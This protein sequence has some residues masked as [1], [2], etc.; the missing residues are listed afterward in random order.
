MILSQRYKIKKIQIFVE[1]MGNTPIFRLYIHRHDAILSFVALN[2]MATTSHIRRLNRRRVLEMLLHQQTASRTQLAKSCEM[3]QPTVSRIVEDLLRE[4]ILVEVDGAQDKPAIGR[5]S[6]PL[7]FDSST[8]RFL[9][10][11]IGVAQTRIAAIPLRMP[12]ADGWK[13][14]FATPQRADPWARQLEESLEQVQ[15]DNHL[16]TVICLPGVIDERN[17]RV[18]LSP[19][20]RWTEQTDISTLLGKLQDRPVLFIQEIKALALGHSLF[21]PTAQ[22]FLL[23]DSGSGVGAAIIMQGRLYTGPLPLSGE[24]GHTSI[25][26]NQRPC[27]CGSKGCIETLISRPGIVATSVENSGPDSWEALLEYLK[28]NE[29]PI[30]LKKSLDAGA[31]VIA[32]SLNVL[33]LRQVVLT[34]IFADLPQS[35]IDYFAAAIRGNSMWAHFGSV[36]VRTAP[37]HRLAGIAMTAVQ[38]ALLSTK[39]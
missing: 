11:H 10:I 2:Q 18:Y 6:T 9:A 15:I 27:G 13:L 35:A 12:E 38:H 29:L 30:W 7:A 36:V 19:N 5:P 34:G 17:G 3:S 31:I 25:L 22:D 1:T 14:S 26:G 23:V 16:S 20:L 33:G 8:P 39:N 4:K 24:L 21:D 32:S 37:R 28:T